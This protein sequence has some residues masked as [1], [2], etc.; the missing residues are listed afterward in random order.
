M[1]PTIGPE[2]RALMEPDSKVGVLATLDDEGCPHLSF[3]SSLQGLEEDQITFGRFCEGLSKN[4]LERRP[5]ARFL[6]LSA[7]MRW[8]RGRA[9]YTHY[10][11]AGEV[12]DAYNNK[13]LFRYNCY[14][15]FN[16]VYFLDLM[17]ISDIAKLPM[18]AIV[19]GAVASRVRAAFSA[20]SAHGA[21]GRIGKALFSQIGAPK[22]L[23]WSTEDG[24]SDIVPVIQACPAGSDRVVFAGPPYAGER[25]AAP[26]GAKAA[27]LCLNL[28]MQSVLVKGVLESRGLLAIDRVYNAMPP[29]NRYIYPMET[30]PE[31][32]TEF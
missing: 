26:V 14:F 7:D 17:D 12:F 5:D 23:C 25:R 21:L 16:R 13:P 22:F 11:N 27:I 6:A 3:I 32:V 8:L 4:F 24:L 18:A 19:C 9:R 2:A 20:D 30:K 10:E 1:H 31:P 28:Q 29:K 15:G